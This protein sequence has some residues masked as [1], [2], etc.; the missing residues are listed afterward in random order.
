ML[1]TTTQKAMNLFRGCL[2][3]VLCGDVVGCDRAMARERRFG[4]VQHALVGCVWW[5]SPLVSCSYGL[6]ATS[7]FLSE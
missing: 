1:A 7:I 5:Q 6:P 2:P 4:G 3:T